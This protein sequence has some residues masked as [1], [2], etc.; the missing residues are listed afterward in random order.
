[1]SEAPVKFSNRE[2]PKQAGRP[3]S[4]VH[5]ADP[6]LSPQPAGTVLPCLNMNS[7]ALPEAFTSATAAVTRWDYRE[8][9]NAL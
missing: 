1:M 4:L 9:T 6:W 7:V 3:L 8:G 5:G 2:E